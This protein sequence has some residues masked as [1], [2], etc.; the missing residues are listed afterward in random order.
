MRRSAPATNIEGPGGAWAFILSGN[1][2][3]ALSIETVMLTS[4]CWP[5]DFGRFLDGR[6]AAD[7]GVPIG[8]PRPLVSAY[9]LQVGYLG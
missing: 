6:S 5:W 3:T 2:S 4:E 8:H 1:E 7:I 9:D